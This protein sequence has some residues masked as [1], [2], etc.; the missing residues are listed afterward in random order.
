MIEISAFSAQ[1]HISSYSILFAHMIAF[2][3]SSARVARVYR[4]RFHSGER[5]LV[6]YI[7]PQLRKCPLTHAISLL[8]PE[9]GPVSDTFK[10]LDGYPSTGVCS[11]C[12]NLLCNRMVGIRLKSS[13][14]TLASPEDQFLM[15]YD[16]S[17]NSSIFLIGVM[18]TLSHSSLTATT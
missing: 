10:V 8:L 12:N 4:L 17:V 14:S 13:L 5:R 11:F 9:P 6:F 3:T 7:P 15:I 16:Y 2:R 18:P 1:E